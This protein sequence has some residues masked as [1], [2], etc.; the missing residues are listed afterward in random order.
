MDALV[1]RVTRRIAMRTSRRGVLGL[2]G[3][4]ILGAAMFPL[5]PARSIPCF[6]S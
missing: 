2:L 4:F 3:K 6:K 5:L 1:E